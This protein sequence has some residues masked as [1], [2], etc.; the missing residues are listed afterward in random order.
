MKKLI[1]L[2][3]LLVIGGCVTSQQAN[4]RINAWDS[5]TLNDLI[6]AWGLPTKTQVISERKFYIWN[7][8]DTSASPAIGLSA[9]SFGRRGGISIGTLF[10]GGSE[11]D[12]CSRVVEVDAG[13]QIKSIKWSGN[14][15]LCFELTPKKDK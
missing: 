2:T 1:L 12:F 9:G 15:E 8:K 13:E 5:V 3:T 4:E 10:G 11:E 7:N 14:P 6:T